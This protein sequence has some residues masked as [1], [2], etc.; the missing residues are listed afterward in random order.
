[1]F[2]ILLSKKKF[3]Y[4]LILLT[5]LLL[6]C[7]GATTQQE[8]EPIPAAAVNSSMTE[9]ISFTVNDEEIDSDPRQVFSS[10]PS[11]Y[12][13]GLRKHHGNMFKTW[14]E[15]KSN[16][17]YELNMNYSGFNL[18]NKTYNINLRKDAKFSWINFTEMIINI[19]KSIS[20]VLYNKT[21]VVK[22][23]SDLVEKAFNEYAND[24]DRVI[25]STMHIYYDAKSPKT[26]C[27]VVDANK[28]TKLANT[29]TTATTVSTRTLQYANTTLASSTKQKRFKKDYDFYAEDLYFTQAEFKAKKSDVKIED[30]ENRNRISPHRH[31]SQKA[32][33]LDNNQ[34]LVQIVNKVASPNKNSPKSSVKS[35]TKGKINSKTTATTTTTTTTPPPEYPEYEDGHN[36]ED[37][38]E[39]IQEDYGSSGWKL[40]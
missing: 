4:F 21:I 38:S 2:C 34:E 8:V 27:D 16:E 1:M 26:F 23:L 29:T 28:N 6:K 14:I 40:E 24:T 15:S 18:L 32:T 7:A 31:H 37:D 9:E 12:D 19:S 20:D 30:Y 25:N 13:G 10:D 35:N 22:N 17:L 36:Y 39:N 33:H 11:L 5:T 3:C